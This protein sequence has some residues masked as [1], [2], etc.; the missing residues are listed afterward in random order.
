MF[1]Y[2]GITLQ[3]ESAF[4]HLANFIPCYEDLQKGMTNSGDI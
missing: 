2:T 4:V 3:L 1:I